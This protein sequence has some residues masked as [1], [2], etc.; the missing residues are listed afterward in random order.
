M[1]L[2]KIASSLLAVASIFTL[3]ATAVDAREFR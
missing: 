2:N 1:K 3:S